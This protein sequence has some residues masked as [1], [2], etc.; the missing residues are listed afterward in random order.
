[1]IARGYFGIGV[2]QPKTKVNVG[3]LWR[4]ASVLGAAFLFT[5]GHRYQHQCSDTMKSFRHIPLFSYDSFDAFYSQMPRL[6]RLV[7][8]EIDEQAQAIQPFIHPQQAV[9]LLGAEDHGLPQKVIDKCWAVVQLPGERCMNVSVAGSI[10][11]FDRVNK[12]DLTSR[13]IARATKI[14]NAECPTL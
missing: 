1:M 10:V 9:Y 4:S 8:V 6:G 12:Q 13:E 11:M 7:G 3:V 5:I 14:W 2:Y